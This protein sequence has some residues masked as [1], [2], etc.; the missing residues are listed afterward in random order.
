M[1]TLEE[2]LIRYRAENIAILERSG[3]IDRRTLLLN[4]RWITHLIEAIK[5]HGSDYLVK[6]ILPPW[7]VR[8]SHCG[9]TLQRSKL[10]CVTVGEKNYFGCRDCCR[11]IELVWNA[12]HGVSTIN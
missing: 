5:H 2:A 8:C 6:D 11:Q 4:N 12:N 10:S 3:E 1:E 7:F 9:I